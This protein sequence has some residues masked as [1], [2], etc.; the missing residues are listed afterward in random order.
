MRDMGTMEREDGKGGKRECNRPRKERREG[1][2][3]WGT[4]LRWESALEP[5][6]FL[7]QLTH[8]NGH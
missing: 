1:E 3:R 7:D 2:R 5:L 8:E 6:L 4:T